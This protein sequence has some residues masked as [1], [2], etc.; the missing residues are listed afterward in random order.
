MSETSS[1]FGKHFSDHSNSFE[2]NNIVKN[3]NRSFPSSEDDINAFKAK[4]IHQAIRERLYNSIAQAF[5]I[6]NKTPHYSIKLFLV[7][8]LCISSATTTYLIIQSFVDYFKYE[9]STTTRTIFEIPS[10]FP[11]VTIC[12]SSPFT[13]MYAFKFLQEINREYFKNVSIFNESQ[14]APLSPE[15]KFQQIWRLYL[16]A[17]AKMNDRQFSMDEREL[18]GY[19]L[20]EILLSCKYNN[21]KCDSNDFVWTFSS[22]YGNCFAFNSASNSPIDTKKSYLAGSMYGFKLAFYTNYDNSLAFFNSIFPQGAQIRIANSSAFFEENHESSF[23]DIFVSPGFS[24]S[25]SIERAFKFIKAK[26]YSNCDI[27]A[28]ESSLSRFNSDL[29]R[30]ISK[31][32]EYTQS[33]CFFECYQRELIRVCNCSDPWFA[34]IIDQGPCLT[35]EET[36]CLVKIYNGVFLTSDFIKTKCVPQ[37]PL[38]CFRKEFKYSI[39]NQIIDSWYYNEKLEANKLF[40]SEIKSRNSSMRESVV[41]INVYYNSLTYT[42]STESQ[43]R[44]VVSLL[45]YVGGIVSLFLGVS[46]FSIFEVIEVL[47]NIY[48]IKK[49]NYVDSRTGEFSLK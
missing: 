22:L 44:D 23:D 4:L 15:V 34:S 39:S 41:A 42:L 2:S 35:N 19:N 26:P 28:Y 9:V 47:L 31:N 36:D 33:L 32:R 48:Y 21:Q 14:M 1:S 20:S 30:E 18:L 27:E 49:I 7:F 16:L 3:G 5:L 46:F 43:L 12:Q 25:I 38:E 10:V 40:S 13:T 8:S 11:M 45:A 6:L 29:F 17:T 37:C 24:T